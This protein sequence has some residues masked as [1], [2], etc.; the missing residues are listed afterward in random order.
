MRVGVVVGDLTRSARR[1]LVPGALIPAALCSGAGGCKSGGPA[2]WRSSAAAKNVAASPAAM[3]TYGMAAADTYITVISRGVEQLIHS[4]RRPEVVAWAR[5]RQ[6]AAAYACFNNASGTNDAACLLDMLVLATL[7][8]VGLEEHW[9]PTLLRD[10]GRPVLEAYRRAE[11][12][13]WAIGAKA[14]T[15][16]QLNEMKSLIEHWRVEYPGQHT[17]S[18]IR[19]TDFGAVQKATPDSPQVKVP[20]S[21]LGLLYLDPLAGLDPVAAEVRSYRTLT[22]R[23]MFVAVRIPIVVGWQ[24]DYAV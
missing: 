20:G 16:A 23:M 22:E 12:D 8:R 4:S 17:V 19:F 21:L 15:R 5:Y 9:I 10:E 24:V 2:L 7:L 18:H 13:V 6:I 1:A 14:L 3:R 11:Q